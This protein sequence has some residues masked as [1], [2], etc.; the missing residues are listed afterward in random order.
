MYAPGLF[1]IEVIMQTAFLI[2][3]FNFYHSIKGLGQRLL[4]FDYT[5]YC[6]HFMSSTDTL[7]SVTYFTALASWRGGEA[8]TRH[9][10]F[11]DACKAS[12]IEVILGKFKEKTAICRNCHFTIKKHEEKATDVNIALRA[13]QLAV[14]QEAGQI[15]LVTGDTD[16]IPAIQMIKADFPAVRVGVVF[17]Y[18]RST[19]ELQQA[20][21]FHHST[22]A[23]ILQRFQLP[24]KI[25]KPNGKT[26]TRPA[27][28]I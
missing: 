2:D 27:A 26:L 19:K 8:V 21:H 22:K 5:A 14:K 20:A 24:D 10:V 11:I 18:N 4:W 16:L 1:F 6:K 15:V 7:H 3:G 23:E 12:G 28:W 17:P 25:K 13:Y 9:Q